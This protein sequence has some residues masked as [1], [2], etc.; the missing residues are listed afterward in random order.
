MATIKEP[1]AKNSLSSG[2]L[3]NL[4]FYYK[5]KKEKCCLKIDKE[6]LVLLQYIFAA[7]LI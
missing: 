3:F 6:N 4:I 5:F 2:T 7:I 1:G